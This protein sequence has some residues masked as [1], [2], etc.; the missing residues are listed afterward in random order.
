[1]FEPHAQPTTEMAID[2]PRVRRLARIAGAFF[3]MTFISSI[4]ALVLYGPVLDDAGYVVGGGADTRIS[5]GAFLEVILVISNVGTAVALF[6]ILRRHGEGLALGYVA[7]RILESTVIVVGI[8]S[9]L[10]VVTLRQD[11]AGSA[12]PG[13]LVLAGQSLVAVHDWT[14]LFGPAFCAGFGNGLVLGYLMYRSGLVPR[15]MALLGIIGGPLAFA[16]ATAVLFG[17]YEQTSGPSFVATLPEMVWEASL[18]IY[19]IAKGFKVSPDTHKE[20]CHP[21][22]IESSAAPAAAAR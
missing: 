5:V 14:F 18:G 12:D 1:M 13:S 9:L 3:V 7:T 6:P 2:D 19:L 20:C 10:S 15:R 22:L 17:L 8:V 16:S 11:V 4:A 21:R